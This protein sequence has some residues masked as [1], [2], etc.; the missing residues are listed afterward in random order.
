M[1]VLSSDFISMMDIS[2]LLFG[3]KYDLGFDMN[4][5]PL[6]KKNQFLTTRYIKHVWNNFQV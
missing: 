3:I 6:P 4:P 1:F 5:S 2:K